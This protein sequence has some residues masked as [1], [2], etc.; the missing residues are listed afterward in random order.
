MFVACTSF[1][2][3]ARARRNVLLDAMRVAS[4]ATRVAG[5]A[6]NQTILDDKEFSAYAGEPALQVLTLAAAFAGMPN[7]SASIVETLPSS[8]RK[9]CIS[10]PD[11]RT[12]A[13]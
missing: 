8:L 2:Q 13:S 12:A 6:F 4:R 3:A 10:A 11:K 7:A 1:V 5:T 9:A